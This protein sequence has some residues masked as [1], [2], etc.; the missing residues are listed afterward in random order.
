MAT[1]LPL[2]LVAPWII[3]S[4]ITKHIIPNRAQLALLLLTE[5][6][7][8]HQGL[9][10]MLHANL[11][12]IYTLLTC[13]II[14][15]LSA[16]RVGMGDVKLVA[17]LAILLGNTGELLSSLTLA[18]LFGLIW[19]ITTRKMVIPFAPSLILGAFLV[20]ALT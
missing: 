14:R 7:L 15:A 12:G 16:S 11:M 1:W 4:D 3:A 10:I 8:I 13:L 5:I 19:V 2:A 9:T 20:L 18:T 17:I 6:S